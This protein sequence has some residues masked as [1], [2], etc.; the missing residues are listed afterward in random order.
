MPAASPLVGCLPAQPIE[1]KILW[2]TLN[3][4]LRALPPS[5]GSL[6]PAA[7]VAGKV[8]TVVACVPLVSRRQHPYFLL[9]DRSNVLPL[10]AWQCADRPPERTSTTQAG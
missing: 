3:V 8:E 7:A 2:G 1:S 10:E 5:T 6:L 4:G 9:S